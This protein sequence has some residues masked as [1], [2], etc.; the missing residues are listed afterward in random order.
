MTDPNT[1]TTNVSAL[2]EVLVYMQKLILLIQNAPVK[3]SARYGLSLM[4][5][6]LNYKIDFKLL[7]LRL[8]IDIF[9]AFPTD[10][11]FV[12]VCLIMLMLTLSLVDVYV[13]SHCQ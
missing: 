4:Y 7:A 11:M 2:L 1:S 12:F 8:E 9:V 5:I 6:Y 3:E 10:I 13:A